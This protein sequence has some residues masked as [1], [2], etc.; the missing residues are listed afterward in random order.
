MQTLA[1]ARSKK[2]EIKYQT[3]FSIDVPTHQ[4]GSNTEI[5][6]KV[7]APAAPKIARGAHIPAVFHSRAPLTFKIGSPVRR[8]ISLA[9]RNP[10]LF[11]SRAPLITSKLARLP[12]TALNVARGAHN[13]ALFHYRA[14]LPSKFARLRC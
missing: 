12:S 1:R 10:A 6:F 11:H 8:R 2:R 13:P 9:A 5:Y 7:G 3:T 14:P 4:I